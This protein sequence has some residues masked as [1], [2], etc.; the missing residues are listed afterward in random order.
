MTRAMQQS[1]MTRSRSLRRLA[2]KLEPVSAEEA[3]QNWAMLDAWQRDVGYL[4]EGDAE[5]P[6]DP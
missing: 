2:D 6:P 5:Q 3:T 1:R 4:F